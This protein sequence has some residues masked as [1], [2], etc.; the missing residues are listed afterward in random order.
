VQTPTF[1]SLSIVTAAVLATAAAEVEGQFAFGPDA[2]HLTTTAPNSPIAT[3]ANA[4]AAGA[5]DITKLATW[6]ALLA[7]V[8]GLATLPWKQ[9]IVSTDGLNTIT[10]VSDTYDAAT[11]PAF[12]AYVQF[13]VSTVVA[14][15]VLVVTPSATFGP[16]IGALKRTLITFEFQGALGQASALTLATGASSDALIIS[17]AVNILADGEDLAS[18][19]GHVDTWNAIFPV[20]SPYHANFDSIAVETAAPGV[21]IVELLS[22]PVPGPTTA[23]IINLTATA[24]L[25]VA[26]AQG[27]DMSITPE[28]IAALQGGATT[29]P[30]TTT[31]ANPALMFGAGLAAGLL[32]G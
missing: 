10:L 30:A 6:R 24:A 29:P 14:P 11:A 17:Q 2:A 32:L 5:L 15:A 7:T 27:V 1:L 25:V 18:H 23:P 21:I 3:S 22:G 20:G 19:L 12:P 13:S 9:V 4:V 28:V 16:A 31:A 26:A 8:P